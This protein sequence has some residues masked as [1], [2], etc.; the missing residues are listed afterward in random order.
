MTLLFELS[1]DQ[2]FLLKKY[3]PLKLGYRN[4]QNKRSDKHNLKAN[5]VS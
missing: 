2:F 1:K 5:L 4:N 3:R